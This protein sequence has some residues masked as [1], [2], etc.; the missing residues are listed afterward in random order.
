[1]RWRC[2]V[3]SKKTAK[4][5]K[6]SFSK[7]IYFSFAPHTGAVKKQHNHSEFERRWRSIAPQ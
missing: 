5:P 6:L 2:A 4:D 7:M 1:V 3:K